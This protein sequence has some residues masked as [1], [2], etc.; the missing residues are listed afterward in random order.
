MKLNTSA[1]TIAQ[2]VAAAIF[3]VVCS[4]FV[5]ISPTRAMSILGN[6]FHMDLS[7]TMRTFSLGGVIVGLLVSTI[8]WGLLSLIMVRT[9]NSLI[10]NTS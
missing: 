9:Y 10:R 6:L 7:G 5:S 8:G 2:M 3:Y 4:L 1:F